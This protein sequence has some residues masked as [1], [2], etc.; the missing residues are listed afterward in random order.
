M[1]Q[2]IHM[3]ALPKRKESTYSY[4]DL[5][6]KVHSNFICNK[7]RLETTQ[8]SSTGECINLVVYPYNGT[9]LDNER[10]EL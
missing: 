6:M 5:C 3:E 2:A 4:K 8:M 10:N 7:P 9:L 1:I